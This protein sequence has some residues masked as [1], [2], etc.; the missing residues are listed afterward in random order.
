MSRVGEIW[1]SQLEP[2]TSCLGIAVKMCFHPLD[3][4]AW[5]ILRWCP[6]EDGNCGND[7]FVFV[8]PVALGTAAVKLDNCIKILH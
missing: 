3:E 4:L 5:E 8:P 1:K 6:S 7:Y 2:K